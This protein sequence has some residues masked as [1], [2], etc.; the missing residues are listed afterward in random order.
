MKRIVLAIAAALLPLAANAGTA[1]G[2]SGT[3]LT[4]REGEPVADALV[5]VISSTQVASTRTD[6]HGNFTFV[7]LTPD[8]YEVSIECRGF[9]RWRAQG[10]V[11]FADFTSRVSAR[12]F[13]AIITIGHID[14]STL[15]KPGIVSDVYTYG[16]TK[17]AIAPPVFANYWMLRMTSGITFGANAPVMH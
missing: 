5:R 7:S 1:G 13:L 2:L 6:A 17:I 12:L 11:V 3:V 15:V 4:A 8:V 14:F 9:D 16:T 10:V